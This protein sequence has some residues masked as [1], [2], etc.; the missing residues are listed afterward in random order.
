[1]IFRIDPFHSLVEFSVKH[2]KISLVKGSF[3]DVRG[4][5]T[6]D[7]QH[8]EQSSIAAEVAVE[9]IYTGA[10]RRDAHLR[11]ANFFDAVAYPLITFISN[12]VHLVDASRCLLS[13]DLSLHGSTQPITFRAAYTGIERDPLTDFWRIGLSATTLIDRRAFG[14]HFNLKIADGIAVVGNETQITIYLEAIEQG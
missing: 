7:P 6:L 13:G 8:P 5:V 11:S 14:M 2:L 4:T 1:M 12:R 3:S 10:S 9:S